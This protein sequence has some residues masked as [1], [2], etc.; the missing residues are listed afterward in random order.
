MKERK[1]R[2]FGPAGLLLALLIGPFELAM[3]QEAEPD[4]LK[5]SELIEVTIYRLIMDPASKNPVVLLSDPRQKQALPIWI[6]FFEANA[7]YSELAGI[8]HSRPLTHDL[9]KRIIKKVNGTVRH[10]VISHIKE[11]IYY[12]TIVMEK[13]GSI[14]EIDARPSDS[15]ALALKF[16]APIF[17]AK[18]LFEN[19]AISLEEQNDLMEQYGLT[20]QNLTPALAQYFSLRSTS[21]VL[22]ANVREG[23]QAEKDGIK[24]GDVIVE[25][26]GNVIENIIGMKAVLTKNMTVAEVKIFRTTGLIFLTLHLK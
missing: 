2:W 17:V 21:G 4:T 8:K 22:V 13:E 24:I 16:K 15:I 10:I 20:L 14:I 1:I 3:A 18:T 11:N 19:M 5:K 25:V 9:L 23:S 12:A 26:E 6:S 7:I